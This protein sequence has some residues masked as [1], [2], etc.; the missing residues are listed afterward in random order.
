MSRQFSLKLLSS[1]VIAGL[2]LAASQLVL[3]LYHDVLPADILSTLLN[4]FLALLMTIAAWR[5]SQRSSGYPRMLWVCVGFVAALWTINFGSGSI[6]LLSGAI[7]SPLGARWP[8]LVI[9]SFPLAIALVLPL[10]LREGRETLEIGW[11]QVLDILQFGIIIFSAFL[12]F[13]LHPVISH[14]Q[15][16]GPCTRSHGLTPDA[17]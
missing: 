6:A 13:F 10:L 14:P 2:V 3:L 16:C 5:A 8:T 9:S 4:C 17:G 7:K 12:V 11:F 1:I 15:R